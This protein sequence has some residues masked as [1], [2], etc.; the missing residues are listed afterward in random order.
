[1]LMESFWLV[2]LAPPN[3]PSFFLKKLLNFE[4]LL[5]ETN[6]V[7]VYSL[8]LTLRVHVNV[9]VETHKSKCQIV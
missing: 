4:P 2:L 5:V 7:H 8:E 9:Q 3:L 1:M 6:V